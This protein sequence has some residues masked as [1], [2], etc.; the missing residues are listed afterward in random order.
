MMKPVIARKIIARK[1]LNG[2][3]GLI[4]T[5]KLMAARKKKISSTKTTYVIRFEKVFQKTSRII[6]QID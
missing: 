6:V 3:R 4:S 2:F 1:L 5:K